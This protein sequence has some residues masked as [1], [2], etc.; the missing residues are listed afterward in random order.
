MLLNRFI[1]KYSLLVSSSSIRHFVSFSSIRHFSLNV[2]RTD[3]GFHSIDAFYMEVAR[4]VNACKNPS[5][6]D[7]D[8]KDLQ[9]RLETLFYIN[10]AS[11]NALQINTDL[12]VKLSQVI[13]HSFKE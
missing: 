1:L 10:E 6:S 4:L 12:K 2:H 11:F 5:L 8:P 3:I 13:D 9:L 7:S